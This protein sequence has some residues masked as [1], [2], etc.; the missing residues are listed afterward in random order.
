MHGHCISLGKQLVSEVDT[1]LWL[2]REDLKAE[3]KSEY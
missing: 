1:F 3:N 2:L